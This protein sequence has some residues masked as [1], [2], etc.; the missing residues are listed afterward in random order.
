VYDITL[1]DKTHRKKLVIKR[2]KDK[3]K[4]LAE[5]EVLAQQLGVEYANYNPQ[6]SQA[7]RE[8]RR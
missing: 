4:T 5:A 2:M 3:D 1:L 6:I 7:T 8:R